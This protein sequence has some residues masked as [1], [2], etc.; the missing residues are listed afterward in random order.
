MEK[1]L[2][3]KKKGEKLHA[4]LSILLFIFTDMDGQELPKRQ[5]SHGQRSIIKE[6]SRID[7]V[8]GMC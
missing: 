7:D 1:N 4:S 3:K 5:W 6:V 8:A 2:I